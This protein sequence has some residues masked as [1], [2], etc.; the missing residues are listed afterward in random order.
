MLNFLK[1]ILSGYPQAKA[2]FMCYVDKIHRDTAEPWTDFLKMSVSIRFSQP[3]ST[4]YVAYARLSTV[5]LTD[6]Q[7]PGIRIFPVFLLYSLYQERGGGCHGRE[8]SKG[9][10]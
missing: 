3:P 2:F 4:F 1:M 6:C 7:K 10:G 8:L 9:H 5:I